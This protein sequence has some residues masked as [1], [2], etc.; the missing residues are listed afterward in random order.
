M[1]TDTLEV[2]TSQWRLVEVGR[3]VLMT[4]GRYSGNLATIVEIIDHKRVLVD[5]PISSAIARH[6]SPL[7]HLILTPLVIKSLPRGARSGK[8][9]KCW[10]AEGIESKWAESAWAK[11]IASKNRRRQL[12]DFDR[13]RVT[14]LRKQRRFDV[15]K[16]ASKATA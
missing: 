3:V 4:D 5:G 15:K 12:N 8:V 1:S 6:A 14:V 9:T 16:A 2:Q 10:E 13:F 7:A 11:K